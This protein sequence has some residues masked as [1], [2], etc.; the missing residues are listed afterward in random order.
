MYCHFFSF[1]F[2][3]FT[4]FC[5]LKLFSSGMTRFLCA[6]NVSSTF[7]YFR[8]IHYISFHVKIQRYMPPISLFLFSIVFHHSC[9][10]VYTTANIQMQKAF[11]ILG[12]VM[13]FTYSNRFLWRNILWCVITGFVLASSIHICIYAYCVFYNMKIYRMV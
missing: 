12:V 6:P 1:G 11:N 5:T 3:S 9:V 8:Q 10:C 4:L 13:Y 7:P 2:S